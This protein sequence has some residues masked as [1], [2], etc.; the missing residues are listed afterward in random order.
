MNMLHSR[1]TTKFLND[2]ENDKMQ[3]PSTDAPL[4]YLFHVVHFLTS[5]F[6]LGVWDDS[7]HPGLP[8]FV[9]V[10]KSGVK[11]VQSSAHLF[12]DKLADVVSLE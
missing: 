4:D 6:W 10:S 1:G 5:G 11:T 9:Q 12:N 7:L 8:P 2:E 3:M